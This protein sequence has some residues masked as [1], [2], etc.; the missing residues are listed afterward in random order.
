M[1]TES[2]KKR[3]FELWPDAIFDHEDNTRLWFS[4]MIVSCT[5]FK[6][7]NLPYWQLLANNGSYMWLIVFK[8]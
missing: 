7:A 3:V 8:R 1:D 2:I 6:Y 5:D 4:V